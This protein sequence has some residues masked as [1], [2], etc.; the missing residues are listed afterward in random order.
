MKSD[1]AEGRKS[2]KIL[3]LVAFR[4]KKTLDD[5]FAHGRDPLYS[6]HL[7]GRMSGSPHLKGPKNDFG[8]R[9]TRIRSS[10][11]KINSLMSE[12]KKMSRDNESIETKSRG[13]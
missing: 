9:L 8:D 6:S 10:L 7:S 1:S 13:R 11:D 5:E 3:D 2:G 12:L 4:Q